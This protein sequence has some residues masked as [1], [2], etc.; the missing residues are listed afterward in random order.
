M[1][2]STLFMNTKEMTFFEKY[3]DGVFWP[4]LKTIVF[5]KEPKF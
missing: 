2:L 4:Y 5:Q 1:A 3:R